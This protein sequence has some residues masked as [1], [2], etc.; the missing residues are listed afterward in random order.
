MKRI[1]HKDTQPELAVRSFLYRNGFRFR[2]HQNSLPGTPDIV[3][4][5]Y[6]TVIFVHGCFWHQHP[7][8]VHTGVPKSNQPYWRPKLERTIHRDAKHREQLTALGWHVEV[9]WE[10]E[11]GDPRF[12]TLLAALRSRRRDGA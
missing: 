8:C 7:G 10:C 3:L 9:V 11:I 6:R 5:R 2:L 12:T 1:R 4:S